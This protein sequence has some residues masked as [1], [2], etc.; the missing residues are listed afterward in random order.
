CITTDKEETQLLA[1]Y[2]LGDNAFQ[3]LNRDLGFTE[4]NIGLKTFV[5]SLKWLI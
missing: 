4:A 1:I 3:G 2:L 5:E